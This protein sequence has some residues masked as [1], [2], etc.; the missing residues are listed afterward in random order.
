MEARLAWKRSENNE[1]EKHDFLKGNNQS[2]FGNF[3]MPRYDV[4]SIHFM[5]AF[6]V[7]CI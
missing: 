7:S 6:D 1:N 2:Y 3:Q 4:V 5:S